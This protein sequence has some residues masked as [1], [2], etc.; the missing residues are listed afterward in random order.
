MTSLLSNTT[1]LAEWEQKMNKDFEPQLTDSPILAF[2]KRAFSFL[3]QPTSSRGAYLWS[4]IMTTIIVGSVLSL[5][6]QSVY[7]LSNT[8]AQK[9]IFFDMELFFTLIFLME[10]I[11]RIVMCP[12]FKYVSRLIRQPSWIVD[13]IAILPFFVELIAIESNSSS[14]A[15][16]RVVRLLRVLRLF[17]AHKNAQ[18]VLILINALNRSKDGVFLLLFLMLNLMFISASFVYFCEAAICDRAPDGTLIYNDGPLVGTP[19]T[20][21]SIP[22]ALWWAIVTV[23][24]IH[25]ALHCWLRRHVPDLWSRKALWCFDNVLR[26]FVLRISDHH[27]WNSYVRTIRRI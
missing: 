4:L 7:D 12:K 1:T 27:Y 5:V 6:L 10:Y 9:Q 2:K 23:F 25:V 22:N 3:T 26:C 18:Q 8:D 19:T 21:Q 16:I 11:T 20:F 17:K 15:V 14:L 24:L 13:F